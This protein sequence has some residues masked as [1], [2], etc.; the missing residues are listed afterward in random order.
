MATVIS[1]VRDGGSL[2]I[3]PDAAI[4]REASQ[5][6]TATQWP[7]EGGASITDHAIVGPLNVSLDL[8]FSPSPLTEL[9]PASGLGRP[10]QAWDLLLLALQKRDNIRVT[11]P[12]AVYEN[13]VLTSLS[14]PETAQDGYTRRF[15]VDLQQVLRV[16]AQES[17]IPTKYLVGRL[18][19]AGGRRKKGQGQTGTPT[20]GKV[21]ATILAI[22][23]P[24]GAT[25]GAAVIG[26]SNLLGVPTSGVSVQ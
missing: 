11:T 20:A 13:M 9:F 6:A 19:H 7:I 4:S 17:A 8:A 10:S 21:A 3:E 22:T 1:I 2:D 12:H 5:S 26:V 18:R 25:S 14:S 23:L 24:G 15:T 16:S